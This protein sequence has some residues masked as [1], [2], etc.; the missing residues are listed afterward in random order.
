MS[1]QKNSGNKGRKRESGV[2]V[3]HRTL[4][5]ALTD[6]LSRGRNVDG[7]HIGRV[8]RKLGNGR[9]DVFY[10][11][12]ELE[13]T[14]DSDG[15]EIEK[16]VPRGHE[17]QAIIKG[18]FRGRGKHSV[19]IEVGGIVVINDTGLGIMEIVGILTQDQLVDISKTSFVDERILKP[20][21]K[22]GAE[23]SADAIEFTNDISD[24]DIDNI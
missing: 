14:F 5:T 16:M 3:R 1:G 18:S 24:D 17:G 12:M 2:A 21:T 7:V 9:V 8:M 4:I 13:K 10:V 15:N 6:D 11:A 22:E 19:W 23:S 20:M